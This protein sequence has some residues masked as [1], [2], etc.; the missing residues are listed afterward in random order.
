MS[1]CLASVVIVATSLVACGDGGGSDDDG[2]SSSTDGDGGSSSSDGPGS[3]GGDEVE[4]TSAFDDDYGDTSTADEDASST[5]TAGES[6]TTTTSNDGSS[7]SDATS[8]SS[9]GPS[10]EEGEVT[11]TTAGETFGDIEADAVIVWSNVFVTAGCFTFSGPDILGDAATWQQSDWD[12]D[13]VFPTAMPAFPPVMFDPVY[14]GSYDEQDLVL[15][16]VTVLDVFGDLWQITETFTGVFG[17]EVYTGTYAYTEC[18]TAAP[19]TC[20]ADGMCI[21]S[22]DFQ[23]TLR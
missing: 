21:V 20:P 4:T 1:R 16:G 18:N 13:L 23:M 15:E 11:T 12:V 17:D 10:P 7:S 6:E 8:S 22:A 14:S 3:S 19:E 5:S 9:D 2:S